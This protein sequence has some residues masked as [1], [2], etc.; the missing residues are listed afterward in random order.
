MPGMGIG[1]WVVQNWFGLLQTVAITTGL[2]ATVHNIRV[3]RRERM[4]TTQFRI[5]AADREIW[6]RLADNPRLDRVL[7]EDVDLSRSPMAI[8]EELLVQFLILH[9][10]ATFKARQA[11]MDFADDQIGLDMRSFF[12]LPI[13][14]EVWRRSRQFQDSDFVEFVERS[15]EPSGSPDRAA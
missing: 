4:V 13:P 6:S 5:A 11:K 8:E 10:R 3:D 9:L 12:T 7:R 1:E 14:R 2:F 15:I